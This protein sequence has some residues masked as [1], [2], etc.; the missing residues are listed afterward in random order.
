MPRSTTSSVRTSL[1]PQ[2]PHRTRRLRL[3]P[4]LP[5]AWI[6]FIERILLLKLPIET[7]AC[8]RANRRFRIGCEGLERRG[9]T[10]PVTALKKIRHRDGSAGFRAAACNRCGNRVRQAPA[11][12]RPPILFLGGEPMCGRRA[13]PQAVFGFAAGCD[14]AWD[15]CAYPIYGWRPPTGPAPS[16]AFWSSFGAL[17]LQVSPKL[18]GTV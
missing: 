7:A 14:P 17:S 15:G 3:L 1:K 18:H 9:V 13:L 12:G 5:I 8:G 2:T 4:T 6:A 10:S 16:A 11:C